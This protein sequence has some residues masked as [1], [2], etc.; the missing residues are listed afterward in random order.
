MVEILISEKTALKGTQDSQDYNIPLNVTE[1]DV[2]IDRTYLT[3]K[4]VSVACQVF[5]SL[6]G[7]DSWKTFGGFGAQGGNI[8]NSVTKQVETKSGMILYIPEPENPN[9][10]IR[11]T[12]T[13]TDTLKTSVKCEFK[14][15]TVK[16]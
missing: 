11:V 12:L 16:K 9:R 8:I 3:D 4:K 7:G 2:F 14:M 10:K 6:D 13:G 5:L 1:A 15:V